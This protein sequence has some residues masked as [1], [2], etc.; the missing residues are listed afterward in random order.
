MDFIKYRN[1]ELIVAPYEADSQLAYLYQ[2]KRIDYVVSEDS[3]LFVFKCL[4]IIK[5]INMKGECKILDLENSTP[6][7][8]CIQS[9]FRLSILNSRRP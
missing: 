3:D 8:S 9:F 5:G 4:R 1:F 2:Q 7:A 6:T